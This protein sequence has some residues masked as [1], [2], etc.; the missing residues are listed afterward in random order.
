[1]EVPALSLGGDLT[2]LELAVLPTFLEEYVSVPKTELQTKASVIHTRQF[3]QKHH[4][5]LQQCKGAH[6]RHGRGHGRFCSTR[7]ARPERKSHFS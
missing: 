2:I 3:H 7:E 5:P 6:G 1:M 4:T